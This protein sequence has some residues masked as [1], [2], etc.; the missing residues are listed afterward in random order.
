MK[1]NG[2]QGAETISPQARISLTLALTE[3][4]V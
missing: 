1:I 3:T 2:D 4:D